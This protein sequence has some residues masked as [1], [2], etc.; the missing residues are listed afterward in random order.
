MSRILITIAYDGR[1]FAG[2]QSQSN[3]LGIQDVLE[4]ALAKVAQADYIRLYGAGRTDSGVHALGQ[5][6]HFDAPHGNKM[7]ANAWVRALNANIPREIRVLAAQEVHARFH[8]RYDACGKTYRYRI[9]NS[10][11]LHPHEPSQAFHHPKPID[12]AL[13]KTAASLCE[14]THDFAAFA[15]ARGDGKPLLPGYA[16]RNLW[17]IDVASQPYRPLGVGETLP[18]LDTSQFTHLS[19]PETDWGQEIALTFHGEGF[20]YKM[21][22]M[23]VGG[24]LRVAGGKSP[25]DWL[26][27]HVH[28]PTDR[29]IPHVAPAAGLTLLRVHYPKTFGGAGATD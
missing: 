20:L 24:I 7:P 8:A 12:L 5:T 18:G 28:E 23:L 29:R 17:K 6:A 16:V 22:R 19:P 3:Q 26:A 14:G 25:L 21:V 11:V 15:A 2:W 10:P 9:L 1:P 13:L 4:A 27:S